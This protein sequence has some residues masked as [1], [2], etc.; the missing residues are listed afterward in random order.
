MPQFSTEQS[1]PGADWRAW[2]ARTT[3]KAGELLTM[4]RRLETS[5]WVAPAQIRQNQLCRLSTLVAHAAEQVPFYGDLF[6]KIGLRPGDPM[7]EDAWGKIP[8]LRR[9]D[10]RDLGENLFARSYPEA[11]GAPWLSTSGGSTGTP[12]R[13]RKTELDAL[14]WESIC[15]REETWHRESV[16]GVIANLRGVSSESYTAHARAPETIVMNEGLLL[17]HWGAPTNSL[18]ETG[19]MGIL[20]P[21]KPPSVQVDFLVSLKPDYLL[22]RPASLRLLLAYVREHGIRMPRLKSVWTVSENVDDSLRAECREALGCR[23]VSNYSASETGYIALQCPVGS[24]YHIMSEVIHVESLDAQGRVCAPGE[25]GRVVVTPLY[26]FAMPLLRYEIGDE[27]EVGAPCACGRGLPVLARISGRLENYLILQSGERLR[28]DL[29]HYRIAAI[30]E[31]REFQLAQT[32][33]TRI[34]LRLAISAPLK[35]EDL[36]SLHA[37]LSK[38]FGTN[39]GWR[40]VY[41]DAIPKTAS[42]KLLQFVSEVGADQG[43]DQR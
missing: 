26:N 9:S 12:V 40:I 25:I 2:R 4:L 18:W 16:R 19:G 33:P 22:I 6:K 39:F 13:A 5:Q 24:G 32:S 35:D 27:A 28:V 15:L 1:A 10:V 37:M 21:G 43:A 7:T 34:E 29:S 38:S 20:Q 11:L 41:L 36:N 31:I 42:G 14:L 23:I 30:R 17:A 3:P 8:I